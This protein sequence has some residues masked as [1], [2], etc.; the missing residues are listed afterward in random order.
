MMNFYPYLQ[1]EQFL[2]EIDNMKVRE[3]YVK[4]TV[5]EFFTE[6]PIQEIQGRVNAGNLTIDGKSSMRRTCNLTV[7]A[8]DAENDLTDI[9]NLF[10][11]NKKVSIEIG[12]KNYIDSKYPDVIWFK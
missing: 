12:L 11:L 2:K 8:G 1:N 9:D 6:E 5:L 3:Q 7:V 10:S 4:I